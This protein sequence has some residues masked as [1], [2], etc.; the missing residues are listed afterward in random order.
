MKK[1]LYIVV[2]LLVLSCE[3]FI[4]ID[5]QDTLTSTNFYQ[6]ASDATSAVNAA[7]DS[8]QNLNYYG[9][10][11]TVL[12]NISG[13]D[14]VKGGFGAG[15]RSEYLEF[16]TYSVTPGNIRSK[17]FFQTAFGGINRSNSVLV[18]VGEMEV[19]GSF[20]AELKTRILGEARFIRALNYYNLVLSF[21]GMPLFESVPTVESDPLPRSSIAETWA[22]IIADLQEAAASLPDTY[23]DANL[24]RATKGAAN[25]MLARISAFSGNWQDVSM[26]A[27]AV[28]NSPAAY[29]LSTDYLSNFNGT[30]NNNEESI[31]EIQYT[32]GTTSLN[33]WTDGGSIG[34]WNSNQLSKYTA[35][36]G[37]PTQPEGGWAFMQPTQ[38]L[39]EDYES[40]DLRLPA[41]IYQPGDDL[42]GVEFD[43]GS[44]S[45]LGNAGQFGLRK[46][47]AIDDGSGGQGAAINYKI[48]RFAE[49]LLLKAEAENEMSATVS[50]AA[51][52]PLNLVRA[53]AGLP[54]INDT[55]NP[56]LTQAML[57]D[58]IF[59]ERRIELAMEGI[60]FHDITQR[61]MGEQVLGPRGFEDGDEIFPIPP[62]EI[63]LTGWAQN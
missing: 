12:S 22:F 19:D 15:D 59:H 31:F 47:T 58:I 44:S 49:V 40:G 20:T 56:G 63:E 60:R 41:T 14:A 32:A 8:F 21:G 52:E 35:P 30:G 7:Y 29:S 3:D 53:R 25:A 61:G 6:T 5:P 28:I 11:F 62:G 2:V 34:D 26:Y 50:A 27:D 10:N 23:D 17:E 24:G 38:D 42:G 51:L 57:R 55:N 46:Y 39:V 43:P 9:F 13:A 36:Q 1:V 54:A 18:N 33:V 48:I 4:D 16:G 45:H 37:I